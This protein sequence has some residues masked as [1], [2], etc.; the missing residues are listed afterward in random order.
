MTVGST[1]FCIPGLEVPGVTLIVTGLVISADAN[2]AFVGKYNHTRFSNVIIDFATSG[3]PYGKVFGIIET[4]GSVGLKFTELTR[5]I[6]SATKGL[7]TGHDVIQGAI[8]AA[9]TFVSELV[10]INDREEGIIGVVYDTVS[11]FIPSKTFTKQFTEL[12]HLI[13]RQVKTISKEMKKHTNEA[14]KAIYD[15]D[16]VVKVSGGNLKEN[17]VKILFMTYNTFGIISNQLIKLFVDKMLK[18]AITAQEYG[19]NLYKRIDAGLNV[20]YVDSTYVATDSTG[21]YNSCYTFV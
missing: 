19:Y 9:V 1:M 15:F 14:F 3:V 7:F 21:G 12:P 11:N 5:T 2:G 8:G 20:L 4:A 18:E 16:S 10:T 6:T 17:V 13:G